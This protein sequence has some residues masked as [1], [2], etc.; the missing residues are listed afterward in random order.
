MNE[1]FSYYLDAAKY[2]HRMPVRQRVDSSQKDATDSPKPESK[3]PD[4]KKKRDAGQPK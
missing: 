2:L 3:K 4:N 1:D